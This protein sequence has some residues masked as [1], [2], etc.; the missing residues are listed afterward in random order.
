MSTP[1]TLD[2]STLAPGA[3]G[4]RTLMF[5]GTLGI[6]LIEGMA[7]A[8]AIGVDFFLVARYPAWPPN[9]V[10]PPD[11][12]WGT[13]NTLVLFGSLVPNELARARVRTKLRP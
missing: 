6:V 13:V 9:G 11:L 12:L 5:W 3:F 8:L 4:S 1:R 7:F 2:V 10:A